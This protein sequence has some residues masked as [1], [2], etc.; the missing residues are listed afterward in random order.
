MAE[1]ERERRSRDRMPLW[2]KPAASL[3]T[4]LAHGVRG[5]RRSRVAG[6]GCSGFAWMVLGGWVLGATCEQWPWD[7]CIGMYCEAELI[8]GCRHCCMCKQRCLYWRAP[9]EV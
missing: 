5:R 8:G 7:C 1:T 3:P 4:G 2:L 6:W 9:V